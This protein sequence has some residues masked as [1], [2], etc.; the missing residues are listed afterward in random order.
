MAAHET[1]VGFQ[2]SIFGYILAFNI[3]IDVERDFVK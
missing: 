3:S 2:H 1:H